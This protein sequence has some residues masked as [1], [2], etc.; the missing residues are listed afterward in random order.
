MTSLISLCTTH[1]SS[2]MP[3]TI[4]LSYTSFDQATESVKDKDVVGSLYATA[5]GHL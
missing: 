5:M 2:S 3:T 1:E 4:V